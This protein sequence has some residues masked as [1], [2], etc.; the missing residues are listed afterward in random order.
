M[1]GRASPSNGPRVG[2]HVSTAGHI[3]VAL[4]N[5]Q[6]I[7]AEAV[8]IFGAAPQQ[9][10][11]KVHQ[12]AEIAAFRRGMEEAGIGP[13][14]IH[15]IYLINL[16]TADPQ[17]LERGVGA[18]TA[19]LRLGSEL[20][21][22]GVIFHVGSHKGAGFA[23]VLP[24]IVDAMKLVLDQ[25]PDDVWLCIENNAGT[26]NSVGSR[27]EEIGAILNGV[28]SGRV[29]TCLDTC[30]AHSAG[31]NLMEK[32]TLAAALEEF[33]RE[34]G[35]DNLVAVHANDSKTPFASGRDRHENIGRGSIGLAGFENLL[36]HPALARATWLLEVPGFEGGG[37]DALNVEILQALRDGTAL[38]RL[39]A[40]AATATKATTQTKAARPGRASAKR[41]APKA[42]EKKQPA[43]KGSRAGP[44][45]AKRKPAAKRTARR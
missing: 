34:I 15:A 28:G 18:L 19:D 40:A 29:K 5:A 11:R 26:G 38:P 35:L 12:P 8:Q 31:Y 24:Q 37:P 42:S 36:H 41:A 44:P 23:A 16:A 20:G 2:A 10:R 33:D 32:E 6:G 3:D 27:F 4:E 14:Y 13:N 45:A 1:P 25:S 22:A 9:W 21:I 30:H 43:A 39:P 7:G 17:L